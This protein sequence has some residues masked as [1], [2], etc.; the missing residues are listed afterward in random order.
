MI[1]PEAFWKMCVWFNPELEEDIPEGLDDI[2]YAISHID[3]QEKQE[4]RDFLAEILT[5]N[6][7]DEDLE[8]IWFRGGALVGF[9][10]RRHYQLYLEEIWRRLKSDAS[11]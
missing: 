9:V 8:K 10:D 2:A 3:H 4:V 7:S 6:Q 5:S 1:A 11:S